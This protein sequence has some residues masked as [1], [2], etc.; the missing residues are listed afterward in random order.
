EPGDA[1][2]A[3]TLMVLPRTDP[4]QPDA[5]RPDRYFLD[6]IC[7]YLDPRRLVTTEV[8]LRGPVYRSIWISVGIAVVAGMG[9]PE[10][11]EN[12]GQALRDFLSPLP[13]DGVQTLEDVTS[14]LR[15]PQLAERRKGWP[16]RKRVVAAELEAVVNR[17]E[18]VLFVNSLLVAEGT[19]AA[20][21]LIDMRG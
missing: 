12:V 3:V 21:A 20:Q 4:L 16:L 11:R 18:G 14:V 7:D 1:P 5:P 10:V 9:V 13:P 17:V 19:G 6:A 2:G 15:A 8:I